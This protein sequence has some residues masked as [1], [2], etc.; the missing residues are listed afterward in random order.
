MD[1]SPPGS[2]VHVIL[3][4]RILE[5][6]AMPSSGSSQ[7][8]SPALQDSLPS[9]PLGK[10][11]NTAVGSLSLLQGIFPTQ[12]LNRGLLQCRR[13]LYQLS[14]QGSPRILQWVAYPFSSGSSQP[15]NGTGVFCTAGGFITGS[16]TERPSSGLRQGGRNFQVPCHCVRFQVSFP[17]GCVFSSGYKC[18]SVKLELFKPF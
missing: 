7:P 11:K 18:H 3:Q 5:W 17:L 6:V 10:P 8:R 12:E 14:H 1:H 4:S 16:A 13:I 15:R 2:S 9:E